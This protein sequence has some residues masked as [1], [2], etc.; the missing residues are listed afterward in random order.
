MKFEVFFCALSSPTSAMLFLHRKPQSV[1][2]STCCVLVTELFVVFHLSQQTATAGLAAEQEFSVNCP[3]NQ[4][5]W[6]QVRYSWIRTGPRVAEMP[7]KQM[8]RG[9]W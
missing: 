8:G 1:F 6:L 4:R 7:L 5:C 3:R 2:C 9:K